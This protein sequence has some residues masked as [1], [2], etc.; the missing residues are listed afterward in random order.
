MCR[1]WQKNM[2]R[3]RPLGFKGQKGGCLTCPR[4]R[5]FLVTPG[6]RCMDRAWMGEKDRQ[7]RTSPKI[8]PC[9]LDGRNLPSGPKTRTNTKKTGMSL[10]HT[11]ITGRMKITM[12]C[13]GRM[14]E[15]RT[16]F[17]VADHGGARCPL[18]DQMRCGHDILVIAD[19]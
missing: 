8:C 14:K 11:H 9:I 5:S 1:C 3:W 13:I 12:H 4:E 17:G 15:C 18:G 6:F 2:Q 7:S 19:T 16:M 10:E